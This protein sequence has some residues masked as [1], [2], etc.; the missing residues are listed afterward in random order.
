MG[1]EKR[2]S[3]FSKGQSWNIILR[4]VK[5]T[6]SIGK[7]PT[8]KISSN[9]RLHIYT[10]VV[11]AAHARVGCLWCEHSSQNFITICRAPRTRSSSSRLC[12][13]NTTSRSMVTD[14][15]RMPTGWLSR[16][17]TNI[18]HTSNLINFDR[19]T[20]EIVTTNQ[21]KCLWIL[22]HCHRWTAKH[23]TGSQPAQVE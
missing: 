1:S 7:S 11:R 15:K 4:W 14:W 23:I 18:Y 6:R 20:L 5:E 9:A 2:S 19:D 17:C 22:T 13:Q 10:R 21:Q 12:S 3:I 8:T 16:H